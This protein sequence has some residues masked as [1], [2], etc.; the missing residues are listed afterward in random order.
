MD[1]VLQKNLNVIMENVSQMKKNVTEKEIVTMDLMRLLLVA[2]FYIV[3][4]L[5]IYV[6]HFNILLI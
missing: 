2:D 3:P 6:R 1:D 4:T 5:H